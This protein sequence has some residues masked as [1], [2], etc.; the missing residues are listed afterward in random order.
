MRVVHAA[1][2]S[3]TFALLLVLPGSVCAAP[4][5]RGTLHTVTKRAPNGPPLSTLAP[6]GEAEST[7]GVPAGSGDP[8][9]EN[10]LSSPLC[11]SSMSGELSSAAQSNCE[12]SSF[13]GAPSPTGNYG[14]DVNIDVGPFGLSKGG[15]L[16]VIQDVFITPLWTVLVWVVHALIV[17]LEWCYTLE[18]LGG[19]TM[20]ALAGSL[21]GA[22]ASFTE[23]WFPLVL[24][25]S[26][27][28]ALYNGLIR[29][30]VADTL[31]QAL[32]TIAMTALGLWVI[33]DPLGTVGV[34][35]Q[36]AN[37]ASF[38][39]LGAIAHGSPANAQRTLGD[40]MRALF[41]GTIEMPWCYLEF[42]NVRW[43]SDSA[44]LDPGLQK[45]ALSIAAGQQA[46]LGC[47]PAL[48]QSCIRSESVPA[49]AN[50]HTVELLREADTNGELFLAFP[51]NRAERNSVKEAKS[52]LHIL[53][54]ADDDT[55]CTG[56]TAA[57]AEFR[58]DS[59][60]FPRMIGVVLIAV[61]VLGMVMLFGLVTLHLLAAA[62]MSLFMLLLAP[63]AVLAPA[64]GDGGRAV[65]VGWLTRLLGAV[66]SKLLFSFL[67]GALLT[68]QRIL[69]SLQALGWWTEWLLIS[70]FWWAVFLKRHQAQT[71]IQS[72]GR[73][74]RARDHQSIGRRVESALQTQ[75]E[76][77]HPVQWAKSKVL[78]PPPVTEQL[79][80]RDRRGPNSKSKPAAE[81][82]ASKPKH[83]LVERTPERLGPHDGIIAKRAQLERVRVARE[84]ALTLGDRRRAAKLAVREQRIKAEL[85]HEQSLRDNRYTTGESNKG[86]QH[87]ASQVGG[88]HTQFGLAA[89][90]AAYVSA[91]S[92]GHIART[93]SAEEADQRVGKGGGASR[94]VSPGQSSRRSVSD[95][96][97]LALQ[98]RN[99]Q[100]I[101]EQRST[102]MED[103]RAVAQRR[104]RQLGFE[105]PQ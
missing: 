89:R 25:A 99:Q 29:R 57:Q 78:P 63:F 76:M 105:P 65:F 1:A 11:K 39:T 71:L 87:E 3:V 93:E 26:S 2:L 77:R 24:A 58:S 44:L 43:C 54:Q 8:L 74:S 75:R 73:E 48:Q 33:A 7:A 4:P 67:L 68:M 84:A 91:P 34:I 53:C 102:V 19:S 61:G 51:A 96:Q 69:M 46:K 14:L 9:V 59:G 52:L 31:G 37:Q 10:G 42:G 90:K 20:S 30:R 36:W 6:Q 86:A 62:V 94:K 45:A 13:V 100:G 98:T 72:R 16:S 66:T 101:R 70:A 60:T 27:V 103:A 92:L 28:L 40:S 97:A 104:K 64:L 88:L 23:P 18:L 85:G 47:R 5:S 95:P 17:M 49:L 80:K 83:T 15:L 79:S 12:T 55:K 38:G 41:A 32:T 35:G 56:S 50:E 81:Q 21:Q 82:S 22:Q